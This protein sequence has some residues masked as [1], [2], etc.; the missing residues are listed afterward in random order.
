MGNSYLEGTGVDKDISKAVN[1]FNKAI[2]NACP[3]AMNT[4]ASLHLEGIGVPQDFK[5]AYQLY[6]DSAQS[7]KFPKAMY[8]LGDMHL[9]G[10]GIPVDYTKAI[11]WFERAVENGA[12]YAEFKLF[13][14]KEKKRK[15][16][17]AL[18]KMK[19]LE[20]SAGLEEGQ[21]LTPLERIYRI[22]DQKNPKSSSKLRLI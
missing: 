8:N 16:A 15:E 21:N 20:Q 6:F 2:A 13:E 10:L 22:M 1:W 19:E 9:L 18:E 3:F 4:L 5:R 17:E 11:M 14:A 7:G 12:K